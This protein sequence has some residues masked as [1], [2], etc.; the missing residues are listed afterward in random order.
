MKEIVRFYL[1]VT[2]KLEKNS[3]RKRRKVV[4]IDLN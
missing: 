2:E 1:V 3:R 4:V